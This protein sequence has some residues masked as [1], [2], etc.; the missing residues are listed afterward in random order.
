MY[1]EL[2]R[3]LIKSG[4]GKHYHGATLSGITSA[5]IRVDIENF[6]LNIGSNINDGHGILIA[7]TKGSGKTC[8]MAIIAKAVLCRWYED[9]VIWDRKLRFEMAYD[10]M[11]YGSHNDDYYS[12]I[13][14]KDVLIVDDLGAEYSHDF[15]LSTFTAIMEYRQANLLSTF[16]TT[17]MSLAR[18]ADPQADE[19]KKYSRIIDRMSDSTRFDIF[20]LDEKSRRK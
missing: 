20:E 16:I 15:P 4:V 13:R 18:L 5:G 9:H 11:R 3:D 10:I 17:N 14:A 7:G 19:Y 2:F 1:N 6:V 8:I 12:Q